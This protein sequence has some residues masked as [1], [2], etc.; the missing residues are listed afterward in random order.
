MMKLPHLLQQYGAYLA[1][2]TA[3]TAM[4]G[5]L[6]YSEMA[7]FVPCTLCWYQRI[8]MYPLAVILLVEFKP[9]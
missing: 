3:L 7:G 4:L 8:F 9:V 2:V 5:S 6:Y 1:F